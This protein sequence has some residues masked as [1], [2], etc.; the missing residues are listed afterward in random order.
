MIKN[1]DDKEKDISKDL[2][3]SRLSKASKDT[4]ASFAVDN[5]YPSKAGLALFIAVDSGEMT[6]E[7]AIEAIKQRAFRYGQRGKNEN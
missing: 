1:I 4:L 6:R 5:I 7:E 2:D 3:L